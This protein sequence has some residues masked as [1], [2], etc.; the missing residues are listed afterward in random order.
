MYHHITIR[1]VYNAHKPRMSAKKKKTQS[2]KYRVLK[3]FLFH[4]TELTHYRKK[5]SLSYQPPLPW[6]P[7]WMLALIRRG[8]WKNSWRRFIGRHRGKCAPRRFGTSCR[9]IEIPGFVERKCI[10]PGFL[11]SLSAFLSDR[12]SVTRQG[13]NHRCLNSVELRWFEELDR[14]SASQVRKRKF[15][16]W[17]KKIEL[18]PRERERER[19][20]DSWDRSPLPRFIEPQPGR[21]RFC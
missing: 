13:G 4:R 20:R 18:T 6:R 11:S 14:R 5:H 16:P 8:R 17:R 2:R 9:H 1:N 19:E 3:N 10:P 12:C 15:A 7:H 21:I